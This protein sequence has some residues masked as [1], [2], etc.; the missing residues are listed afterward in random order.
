M[1]G[2]A[3]R[4]GLELAETYEDLLAEFAEFARFPELTEE[5]N[6]NIEQSP[7]MTT[8]TE[9]QN[10]RSETAAVQNVFYK[11]EEGSGTSPDSAVEPDKV[12]S[13]ASSGVEDTED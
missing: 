10:N 5:G 1:S 8:R 7:P 11:K 4:S 6:S 13:V 2:L 12:S 3:I 9:H